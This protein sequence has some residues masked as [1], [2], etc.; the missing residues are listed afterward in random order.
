MVQIVRIGRMFYAENSGKKFSSAAKRRFR[1]PYAC[2]VLSLNDVE[3]FDEDELEYT[4]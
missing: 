4:T 1:R 2:G 3:T